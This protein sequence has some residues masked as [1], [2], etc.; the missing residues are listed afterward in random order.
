MGAVSMVAD[1]SSATLKCLIPTHLQI[2]MGKTDILLS[3]Q[4]PFKLFS[5]STFMPG[6]YPR[7][8]LSPITL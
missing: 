7:I 3:S 8:P 1:F 2:L 5:P 4:Q 6:I